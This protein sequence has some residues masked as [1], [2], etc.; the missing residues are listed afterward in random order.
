MKK[1]I[2]SFWAH[3]LP[4]A[5]LGTIPR[6]LLHTGAASTLWAQGF[7]KLGPCIYMS[8]IHSVELN[9]EDSKHP[10]H[11]FSTLLEL[12]PVTY[13][14]NFFS[15]FAPTK[16]TTDIWKQKCSFIQK[17]ISHILPQGCICLQWHRI[18][19]CSQ[20]IDCEPFV[21]FPYAPNITSWR[22]NLL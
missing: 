6:T 3:V 15:D 22:M 17:G 9:F 8:C 16:W 13:A 4:E 14:P 21:L 20:I 12:Y 1:K 7:N 5:T 2:V 18:D 10:C 11:H 19:S